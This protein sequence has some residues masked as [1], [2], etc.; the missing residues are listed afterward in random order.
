MTKN[1]LEKIYN[2][3]QISDSLATSGQPTEEQFSDLKNA[4]YQIVIN[5]ALTNSSNALPDEPEIVKNLDMEYTHIPVIWEE[6][7]LEDFNSFVKVMDN[8]ADKNI[9]VHCAA[10]KRVSA[11]VYLYRTQKGVNKEEAK[12]DLETIWTPNEVWQNFI[13]RVVKSS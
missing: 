7:T 8:N 3:L 6:P 1:K 10:N 4:G 9:F 12:K 2:F 13:D 11:F 5:L